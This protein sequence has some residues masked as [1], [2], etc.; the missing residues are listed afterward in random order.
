MFI[1]SACRCKGFV[2]T[3]RLYQDDTGSWAAEVR[4]FYFFLFILSSLFFAR[5]KT[6]TDS[7]EQPHTCFAVAGVYWVRSCCGATVIQQ[8]VDL[9]QTCFSVLFFFF[10]GLTSLKKKKKKKS[11]YTP[12]PSA[13]TNLCE[14]LLHFESQDAAASAHVPQM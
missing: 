4:F 9:R 2:Y 11:W 8:A 12:F 7:A 6:F 13:I 10:G 14:H 1:L 3:Y 5:Q